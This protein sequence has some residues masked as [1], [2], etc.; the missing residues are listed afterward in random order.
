MF[1]QCEERIMKHRNTAPT[2]RPPGGHNSPSDIPQLS[3]AEQK[4]WKGGG[5]EPVDSDD[6]GDNGE[7]VVMENRRRMDGAGSSDS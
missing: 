1:G 3:E 4:T 2:S 7:Y 6:V 5:R